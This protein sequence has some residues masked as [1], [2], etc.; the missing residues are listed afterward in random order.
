[1]NDLHT[2]ALWTAIVCA[3]VGTLLGI[4]GIWIR[5][6]FESDLASKLFLTDGVLL[7][8]GVVIA[9]VTKWLA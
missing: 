9:A 4:T 7:A 5:G 6:F 3:V 2:V 8:G 1:M